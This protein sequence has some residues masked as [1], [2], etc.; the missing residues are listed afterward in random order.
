MWVK[1]L[2]RWLR[3]FA[4]LAEDHVML[5]YGFHNPHHN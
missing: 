5:C 1:E 4:L 3:A 2:E